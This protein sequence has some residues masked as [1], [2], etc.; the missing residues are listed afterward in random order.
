MSD[1]SAVRFMSG[2]RFRMKG[3]GG[4]FLPHKIEPAPKRSA[5]ADPAPGSEAREVIPDQGGAKKGER[6]A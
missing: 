3:D 4:P 1:T 5:K 2:R 6:R